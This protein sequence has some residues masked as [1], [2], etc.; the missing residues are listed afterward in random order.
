MRPLI[1]Q[2]VVLHATAWGRE[3]HRTHGASDRNPLPVPLPLGR[4]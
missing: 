2:S 1:S 4:L 3:A